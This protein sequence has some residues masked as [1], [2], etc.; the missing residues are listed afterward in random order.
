MSLSFDEYRAFDAL[1]L[2]EAIR[3]GELHQNE[4][5]EA[6]LERLHT[7]NPRINA[8]TY[9]DEAAVADARK[10]PATGPLGGVPYFIKDLH[11]PV[12][13][14][15]LAHGSRLFADHRLD[16]DSET[17][18][19]LRRAGLRILGRTASSEFGMSPSTET[20]LAGPTRNPWSL[21]RIAGGSSG[22]AAAAVAAGI[23]PA[24]HATDS[25]GSIRIPAACNGLVGLKP[26]RG[27][28]PT[29]PH[30]GDATHGL[31]HE[32]AV[33]RSIRDCAALLDATAGPDVGAPYYT[34]RPAEPFLKL[35]AQPPR[36]LRIAFTTRTFRNA[37]VHPECE[38]A[39]L[40]TAKHLEDMGHEVEPG[41]PDFDPG[42]LSAATGILLLTGLAAQL[43]ARE[44]VLGRPAREDELE[45]V[46]WEA[47]RLSQN[48]SGVD[49]ASQFPRINQEVRKIA[50]FFE[51]VDVLLT[52]TL[53]SPPVELGTLSTQTL[54]L[55]EF[56]KAASEFIPFTG[57]FNATGQPAISLPLHWT[58]DGLPLGVQL[59]GR[60]GEDATLLQ[61]SAEIERAWPWFH[62]TAPLL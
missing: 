15:P 16:F 44:A 25:G 21:S 39:V 40:G 2:A 12:K 9:L 30:R 59:V 6:A 13:G 8:V 56:Q 27:L 55:T 53:G 23:L 10:A 49:Y 20:A 37:S 57:A 18:V 29:G 42:A 43:Q 24:S 11:A 48:I 22:G 5:L 4:V 7:V 35:I 47:I 32:H 38:A 50:H 45:R 28:L 54:S 17:V 60:F 52:P 19:R 41:M 31:S 26:T 34:P 62:R 1:G 58:S 33:T 61:L 51:S 14:M 36:K 3:S 46:T